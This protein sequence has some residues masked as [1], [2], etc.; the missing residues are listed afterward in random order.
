M[1][2]WIE[3]EWLFFSKVS[4]TFLKYKNGS[5]IFY[6]LLRSLPTYTELPH[7]FQKKL[8][9]LPS[10]LVGQLSLVGILATAKIFLSKLLT[11]KIFHKSVS[12]SLGIFELI[13]YLVKKLYRRKLLK[14]SAAERYNH[15]LTRL[16]FYKSIAL[17]KSH[18]SN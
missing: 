1:A 7:I 6:E 12:L 2:V 9:T 5:K 18:I 14:L 17:W 11:H 3:A 4:R 10:I 16:M 15:F 13:W 8:I